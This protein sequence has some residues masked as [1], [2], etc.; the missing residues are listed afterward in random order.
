MKDFKLR[1]AVRKLWNW[2]AEQ[3]YDAIQQ[4]IEEEK[5]YEGEHSRGRATAYDWTKEEMRTLFAGLI[6]FDEE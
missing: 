5:I 1:A 3:K 4:A 6:D 2:V